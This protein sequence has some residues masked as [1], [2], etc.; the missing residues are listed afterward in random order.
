MTVTGYTGTEDPYFLYGFRPAIASVTNPV[1][2]INY[3]NQV[4]NP[5]NNEGV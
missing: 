1:N 5:I 2:A 3:Y 4:N